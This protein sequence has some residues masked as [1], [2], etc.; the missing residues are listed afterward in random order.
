MDRS[1]RARR[2]PRRVEVHVPGAQA[3]ADAGA[4]FGRA[5][6]DAAAEDERAVAVEEREVGADGGDDRAS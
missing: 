5:R 2:V 6:A 4:D 3:R 1:A